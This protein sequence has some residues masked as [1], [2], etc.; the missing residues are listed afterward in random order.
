MRKNE[1][2]DKRWRNVRIPS[3]YTVIL[4]ATD[5][6]EDRTALAE[7]AWQA[8]KAGKVWREHEAI[9]SDDRDPQIRGYRKVR[10]NDWFLLGDDGSVEG[11]FP[12]KKLVL[13]K[14]RVKTSTKAGYGIYLVPG[15]TIFTREVAADVG[16]TRRELAV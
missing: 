9:F 6:E 7:E 16:L 2:I 14:L 3:L 8:L 11:P 10:L 1:S 12:T 15:W 4:R 13:H 5:P